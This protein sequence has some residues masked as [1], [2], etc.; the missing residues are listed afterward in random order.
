MVSLQLAVVDR[1]IEV[2]T[3]VRTAESN[4]HLSASDKPVLL[5]SSQMFGSGKTT[6]GINAISLLQQVPTISQ[7][8]LDPPTATDDVPQYLSAMREGQTFT[9]QLVDSYRTARTL[10]VDLSRLEES[11]TTTER[12]IT[13]KEALYHALY[14]AAIGGTAIHQ[15]LR[16][17]LTL[18]PHSL[19]DLLVQKTGHKG[20]WF[21]FIDEIGHI[22]NLGLDYDDIANPGLHLT[23][24][25]NPKRINGYTRLFDILHWFL[26]RNDTFVFCAGKSARLTE[27]SLEESGSPVRYQE[28][29]VRE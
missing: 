3:L 16:E 19:L 4:G 8:L 24:N 15:F 22:E 25:P 17:I 12:R 10:F 28:Q 21:F 2:E 5:Y 14:C 29:R 20:K 26:V 18:S 6:F 13:F 11:P 7:A 1:L 9:P 23:T 27:K